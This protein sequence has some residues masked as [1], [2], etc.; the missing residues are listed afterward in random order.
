M[1]HNLQ[2]FRNF[3]V[4]AWRLSRATLA[5][6][7]RREGDPEGNLTD[8]LQS[9]SLTFLRRIAIDIQS[10][11][12]ATDLGNNRSVV[13]FKQAL[14]TPPSLRCQSFMCPQVSTS[15]HWSSVNLLYVQ[16]R[17]DL[18]RSF[19]VFLLQYVHFGVWGGSGW[20]KSWPWLTVCFPLERTHWSSVFDQI[21]KQRSTADLVE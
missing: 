17:L 3:V 4:F 10:L 5:W 9:V 12:L 11:I 15:R 20:L 8:W 6:S 19:D 16:L 2:E 7:T 14:P 13:H 1:D 21:C 18:F